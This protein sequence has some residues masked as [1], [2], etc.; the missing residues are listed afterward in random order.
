MEIYHFVTKWFFQA[1]PERVW[2]ESANMESYPSW[3]KDL[4]KAEIRGPESQLQLGSFVDCEVRGALPYSLRFTIEVTT[5]QPPNLI[6]L[7][8]SGDLVGTG[9]WVLESKDDGTAS[10]FYWDVGTTNRILNLLGKLPFLRKMLEKNHD[11]VMAKG[12]K[13]VK[14][15]IEG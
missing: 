11:D 7:K 10:T 3:W 12:Y 9:R 13:V 14:S 8:S 2:E 6:E 15:K 4:K 1:P 5:Y